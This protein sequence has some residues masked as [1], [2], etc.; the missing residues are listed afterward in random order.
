MPQH[1]RRRRVK[2]KSPLRVLSALIKIAVGLAIVVVLILLGINFYVVASTRGDID[3]ADAL[4]GEER[5]AILVLGAGIMADGSPSPVLEERLD[6]AVQLYAG[7][8]S[9]KII[10]SGGTDAADSEISAM[11]NYLLHHDVPASAII[12]D[13]DGYNTYASVYNL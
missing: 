10:V 9:E 13:H 8:A 4:A 1:Q 6:S 5:D 2:K 7:G 11:R 3:T 12:S